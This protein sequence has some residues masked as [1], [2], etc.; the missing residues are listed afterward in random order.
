MIFFLFEFVNGVKI[1][2]TLTRSTNTVSTLAT[3]HGHLISK[4][5]HFTLCSF[6]PSRN[7]NIKYCVFSSRVAGRLDRLAMCGKMEKAEGISIWI[8]RPFKEANDLTFYLLLLLYLHLTL[9]F[10]H[11]SL[12][13]PNAK[14]T[15]YIFI[16]PDLKVD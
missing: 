10:F 8:C 7:D 16:E 13:I 9:S 15:F 11:N 1:T 5:F 4:L 12:N 3:R 14:L 6:L 2:F